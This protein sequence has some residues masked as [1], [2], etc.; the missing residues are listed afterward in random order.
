MDEVD[1][2]VPFELWRHALQ[3]IIKNY[4]TSEQAITTLFEERVGTA[5]MEVEIYLP[6][7]NELLGYFV[8]ASRINLGPLINWLVGWFLLE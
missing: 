3:S 2:K 7:F 4:G 1:S 5:I 8:C 6:Y